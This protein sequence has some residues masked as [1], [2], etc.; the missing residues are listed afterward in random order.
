VDVVADEPHAATI[1][2]VANPAASPTARGRVTPCG[3]QN[4]GQDARKLYVAG[5]ANI[6]VNKSSSENRATVRESKR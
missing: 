2:S 5:L 1:T 3:L 6:A 4:S